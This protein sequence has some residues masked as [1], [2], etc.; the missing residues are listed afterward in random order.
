M[1]TIA[2]PSGASLISAVGGEA[3]LGLFA[4]EV[5]RV[6]VVRSARF[7]E[8][9]AGAC[10]AFASRLVGCFGCSW[11][12]AWSVASVCARGFGV[13]LVSGGIPAAGVQL[14]LFAAQ[15]AA[16]TGSE[17]KKTLTNNP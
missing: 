2:Y 7:S 16:P 1:N 3:V 11:W 12:V 4:L 6:P 5:Q 10:P 13:S 17:C 9:V 8:R 14:S 15:P